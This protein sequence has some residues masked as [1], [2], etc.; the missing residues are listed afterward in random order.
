M[1]SALHNDVS[2]N[3]F[4]EQRRAK[5]RRPPHPQAHVARN[6][7]RR[8]F[9]RGDLKAAEM[10]GLFD[11]NYDSIHIPYGRRFNVKN[12][13]RLM[14][15]RDMVF[16]AEWNERNVPPYREWKLHRHP[17]F[18]GEMSDIFEDCCGYCPEPESSEAAA[19]QKVEDE[20]F[21]RGPIRFML[22]DPG[23]QSVGS[24]HPITDGDWSEM[25]YLSHEEIL[26]SAVVQNDAEKVTK[27]L[28][29]FDVNKRDHT[30]R[31]MLFLAG[32]CGS[33]DVARV[34]VEKGA[35]LTA[36]NFDGRTI[37]HL[38]CQTGNLKLLEII[39]QKSKAN[40][41]EKENRTKNVI[42]PKS[43]AEDSGGSD[44]GFEKINRSEAKEEDEDDYVEVEEEDD[45]LDLNIA[46]WDYAFTPLHH[47]IFA[48]YVEIVK[49]LMEEGADA[50]ISAK[51]PRGP[52]GAP[53]N[54][55][56]Q[57]IFPI[58][59]CAYTDNGLEIARHIIR[60]GISS[61]ADSNANTSLHML[62]HRNR[63]DLLKL[64]IE[65]DPKA[66]SVLNHVPKTELSTPLGT[67]VANGDLELVRLFLDNGASPSISMA[68]YLKFAESSNAYWYRYYGKD[69][70][71]RIV[72]FG[73][74]VIQP[75]ERAIRNR[76]LEMVKLL[77]E[78]GASVD[79]APHW[80][81]ND[82]DYKEYAFVIYFAKV[83]VLDFRFLIFSTNAL[84]FSNIG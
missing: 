17:C 61:Q 6:H 65:M 39:L 62:V 27:L 57:T 81:Y 49:R 47:A 52:N 13:E 45:I 72:N 59:L 69:E 73:R 2:M 79:S 78:Y 1:L 8:N 23:R 14:F 7:R 80:S 58:V 20:R 46:D 4:L 82:W 30:G 32:L 34:L 48:G 26:A 35:R 33:D 12:T 9:K 37:L 64:L 18:F 40:A 41:L 28:E 38:A 83:V 19:V 77:V 60:E 55:S 76:N 10:D 36:R 56:K 51:I 67:A 75:L 50:T 21:V 53:W 66:K 25:A 54:I 11:N 70:K 3:S 15:Q 5:R 29:T 24:F 68:Q 42:S 44:D 71:K 84:L 43:D 16:N 74:S 22:D 63:R 31:T